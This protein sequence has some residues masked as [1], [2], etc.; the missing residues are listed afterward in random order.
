[1]TETRLQKEKRQIERIFIAMG[2]VHETDRSDKFNRY[3]WE[4][5]QRLNEIAVEE[6]QLAKEC[7][8]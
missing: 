7:Q 2:D 1:M 3:Y 4:L 6:K 5:I 8:D